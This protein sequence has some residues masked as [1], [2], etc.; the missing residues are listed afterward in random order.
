LALKA[1]ELKPVP[2]SFTTTPEVLALQSGKLLRLKI[3][4]VKIFAG[5][6]TGKMP[7]LIALY[8]TSVLAY[9][10]GTAGNQGL[11]ETAIEELMR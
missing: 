1:A 6:A 5:I 2:V 3:K 4:F 7:I 8:L 11:R 10:R 9:R